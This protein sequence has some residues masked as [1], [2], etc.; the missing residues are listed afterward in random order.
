MANHELVVNIKCGESIKALRRVSERLGDLHRDFQ[1]T[2][3]MFLDFVKTIE[4]QG[5][6]ECKPENSDTD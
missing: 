4:M 1:E 2:C 5:Q 3:E 6:H